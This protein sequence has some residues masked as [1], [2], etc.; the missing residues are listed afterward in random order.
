MAYDFNL[1]YVRELYT[2]GK[3]EEAYDY[4]TKYNVKVIDDE[5]VL[6][7]YLK[8]L[9]DKGYYEELIDLS[10]KGL[11]RYPN[12]KV[13]LGFKGC[14][15]SYKAKS[16]K[17][18]SDNTFSDLSCC[19]CCDCCDTIHLI[20]FLDGKDLDLDFCCCGD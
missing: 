7:Q 11:K 18:N 9:S 8:Y 5:Y 16:D 10:E 14:G 19:E 3:V 13:I 2:K 15:S 12:N 20:D 17:Y 6:E 1:G 4:A